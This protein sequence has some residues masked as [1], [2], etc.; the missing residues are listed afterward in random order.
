DLALPHE[1]KK[2]L[3]ADCALLTIIHDRKRTSPRMPR[4]NNGIW[5]DDEDWADTFWK[6]I[7][8]RNTTKEVQAD[9]ELTLGRVKAELDKLPAETGGGTNGKAG[10]TKLKRWTVKSA[11]EAIQPV[12]KKYGKTPNV[13]TARFLEEE[14]GC[15]KS[16][17]VRTKNWSVLKTIKKQ[18][19]NGQGEM[20]RRPVNLSEKMLSIAEQTQ[21]GTVKLHTSHKKKNIEGDD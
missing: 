7:K 3:Q 12:I 13:L 15:P 2:A 19:R 16:T 6:Q 4:I 9:V 10:D 20:Q 1:P 18:Y 5:S 21:D 17:L 14:T 11:N 8:A